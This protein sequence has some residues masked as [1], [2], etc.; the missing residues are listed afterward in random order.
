MVHCSCRIQSV[1]NLVCALYMYAS[2]SKAVGN[3]GSVVGVIKWSRLEYFIV[4]ITV[5]SSSSSSSI[6]QQW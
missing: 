4:F 3:C 5:S 1:V 2:F 6:Y